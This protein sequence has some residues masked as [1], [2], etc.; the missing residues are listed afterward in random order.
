MRHTY[1]ATLQAYSDFCDLH[2]FPLCPTTDTL[3]F[4]VVYM[5]HRIKPSSVKSYLSGICVELEPMWPDIHSIRTSPLVTKLLMG[6]H[7]LFRTPTSQKR[8][9][10]ELDLKLV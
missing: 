3:S 8:A 9:L 10:T 1:A 2:H 6:C 4:F 5:S 7:K